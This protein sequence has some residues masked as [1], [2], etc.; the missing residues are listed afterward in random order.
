[1]RC[2]DDRL[3]PPS[4]S[5]SATPNVLLKRASSPRWAARATR[6]TMRWRSR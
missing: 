2:C 5:R 4:T 6:T 1:L 3:N